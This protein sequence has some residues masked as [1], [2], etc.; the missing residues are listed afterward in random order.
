MAKHPCAPT[1]SRPLGRSN[2]DLHGA[3]ARCGAATEASRFLIRF[4]LLSGVKDQ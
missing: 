3:H 2:G 4:G 1:D